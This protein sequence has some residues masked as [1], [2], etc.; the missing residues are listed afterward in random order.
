MAM[1]TFDVDSIAAAAAESDFA[2]RLLPGETIE[3]GFHGERGTI[4]FTDRRM[5]TVQLL[6][7]ISERIE[8]S[9]YSY[10]AVRSFSLNQPVDGNGRSELRI[11]LDSDDHPLHLRANP[12]TDFGPVIALL[13][14]HLQ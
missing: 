11:I 4:L 5:I 7:V 13:T 1:R 9:S 8:T 2:E 6:V 14:H 12:G 3:A 10:R